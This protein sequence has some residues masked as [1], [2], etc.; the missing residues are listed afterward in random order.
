M[1]YLT[2]DQLNLT[3]Y[4][5]EKTFLDGGCLAGAAL[6]GNPPGDAELVIC[7]IVFVA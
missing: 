2:V 5:E 4:L 1:G 7:G 3:C 6:E